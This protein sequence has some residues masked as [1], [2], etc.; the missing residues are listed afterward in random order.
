MTVKREEIREIVSDLKKRK[1]D[2][3]PM[4]ALDAVISSPE[5][6]VELLRLALDE[7]PEGG[8]F[9]DAAIGFL[10]DEAFAELTKLALEKF[11][12]D[13][14]NELA[15][16]IL[17]RCSI[18]SV[19]DL[20]PHL[21]TIFELMPNNGGE[22]EF[23]PWHES[24]KRHLAYLRNVLENDGDDERRL[25]A[26]KAMLETRE[27]GVLR[28]AVSQAHRVGMSER[29]ETDLLPVGFELGQTGLRKLYA[30]SVY[31]IFF[32][33]DYL[34][35]EHAPKAHWENLIRQHHPTWK[36]PIPD[37]PKMQFG[38][39][40]SSHCASCGEALDHIITLEPVLD[41]LGITSL[42]R[43]ELATCLSC[44]GGEQQPFFY[45][46]DQNGQPQQI[47]LEGTPL[48]P[49]FP[50]VALKPTVVQVAEISPRWRWQSDTYSDDVENLHR[51]GGDPCWI[52]YPEYPTCPECSKR[53]IFLLQIM[54]G[55]PTVDGGEWTWG[56]DGICYSFWC[57]Q[58]RVSAHLWQCS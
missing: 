19:K 31:H 9:L 16:S 12:A 48:T 49:Q 23:W 46:H 2:A 22:G 30:D 55:L 24:G 14:A 7:I 11:Q 4:R 13:R 32:P 44:L 6:A 56:D 40:S 5:S 8:S 21:N 18:Q 26:W 50:S 27:P 34:P 20:H 57:D 42:E 38:G 28:L 43:L 39:R 29:P 36:L 51:V 1:S 54:S 17:L 25:R 33:A 15:E 3:I 35:V 10:P 53:M 41:T 37:A 47:G 52:Q 58:C 45:K